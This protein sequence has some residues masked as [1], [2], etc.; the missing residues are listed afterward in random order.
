M[1][2]AMC[3]RPLVVDQVAIHDRPPR[4]RI[5]E[6]SSSIG[7][8]RGESGIVCDVCI[9]D[10][11]RY[12]SCANEWDKTGQVLLNPRLVD[13]RFQFR[14]LRLLGGGP[15]VNDEQ[16]DIVTLSVVDRV[17]LV[18]GEQIVDSTIDIGADEL[19][20]PELP[21]V[22]GGADSPQLRCDL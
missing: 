17:E 18:R 22:W 3:P 20:H 2:F 7:Y 11:N 9:S 12:T 5:S 19:A 8:D 6:T 15:I 4:D 10:V 13:G 1:K 14:T 21:I 16:L